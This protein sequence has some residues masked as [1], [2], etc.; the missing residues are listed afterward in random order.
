MTYVSVVQK[1]K[2]RETYVS[3]TF[4]KYI[5]NFL[6]F[7]I[8][9]SRTHFSSMAIPHSSQSSTFMMFCAKHQKCSISRILQPLTCFFFWVK[10]TMDHNE[11][12]RMHYKVVKIMILNQIGS[13]MAGS[14]IV[15]S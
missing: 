11:L 12:M 2:E 4:K 8:Q 13:P 10:N 1:K 14:Q 6:M 3:Y 7:T 15:G 5:T 9:S